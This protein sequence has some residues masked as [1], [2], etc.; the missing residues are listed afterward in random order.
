MTDCLFCGIAA[1]DVPAT[2][3]GESS[4]T[5]AFRDT[6]PMAPVHVLVIPREHHPDLAALARAGD[7]LLEEVAAQA[8]LVAHG[9]GVAETGY[10]I[11]FNTG[12]EAGQTVRHAHAHV[13]GGR[14]LSW[15]PG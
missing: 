3:V 14:S 13:L 15:P 9:E 12:P 4:R 6:N 5:V 7:G 11:V 2:R 8:A 10:R 1:G